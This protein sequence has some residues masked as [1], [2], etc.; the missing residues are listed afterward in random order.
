MLVR[1]EW[2]SIPSILDATSTGWLQEFDGMPGELQQFLRRASALE[3]MPF[4]RS[5][6][7]KGTR[8][9]STQLIDAAFAHSGLQ[10]WPEF[11]RRYEAAGWVSYSEVMVTSEGLDALVFVEASCGDLCGEGVYH[12]LHRTKP[13]V[14]WSIMKSITS[15]IV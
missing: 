12:W 10:G 1:D 7:P 8:F 3:K 2:I 14:A 4:D 5:L 13:G 9:I 15:F 11:R 6:F